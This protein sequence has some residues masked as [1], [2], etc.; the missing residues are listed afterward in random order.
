MAAQSPSDK[1]KGACHTSSPAA[2]R[3]PEGSSSRSAGLR[4]GLRGD[5]AQLDGDC[6]SFVEPPIRA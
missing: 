5:G 4:H 2:N 1:T 6:M 3:R